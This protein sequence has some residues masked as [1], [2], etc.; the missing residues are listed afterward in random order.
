M[1]PEKLL[2]IL[3]AA[4]MAG[5][6]PAA[7]P[8]G[9]PL[10]PAASD[11]PVRPPI[12][13]VV[14]P[15]AV[16][17]AVP[18]GVQAISL[19]GEELRSAEASPELV[20]RLE[21]ARADYEANPDDAD[22]IIWYGRRIAYAGDYRGAVVA[23]SEGI[24]K[25]PRDARMYRH[26]GHRYISIRAFDRAI[27]DLEYAA[28][29]IEGTEDQV[30]PDGMP[31]PMNIPVS[32]LHSNI[33]YHLGLAYY[34]KGDLDNALRIYRV[35]LEGTP[36]DDMRVAT[37]HWLYMTLRLLGRETDAAAAL[38][39]IK[40]EMNVIESMSYHQLCLLYKGEGDIATALVSD[41]TPAGGDSAMYGVGNWWYYN[42][43]ADHAKEMF[44]RM[45][46]ESGWASFGR[47][48]AESD[49]ARKF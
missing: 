8:P 22:S 44:E 30:E 18:E 43:E 13:S 15:A 36:N 9:G 16:L 2:L 4:G 21:A 46:V 19:L 20:A 33:W 29:L 49:L 48:A 10:E 31:N 41:V 38:E 1:R 3:L 40:A 37:T 6:S 14:D 25:F 28:A 45:L 47:I 12:G 23:F 32:T 5:C 35:A 24:R 42:G 17:P 39:P 11:Q 34:L 26:R 27:A 7:E